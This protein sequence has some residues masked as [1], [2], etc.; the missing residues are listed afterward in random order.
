MSKPL[1]A[2]TDAQEIRERLDVLYAKAR[3]V[4]LYNESC[5]AGTPDVSLLDEK[6]QAKLADYGRSPEIP[7]PILRTLGRTMD[8]HKGQLHAILNRERNLVRTE[9]AT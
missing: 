6:Q 8:V 1:R 4:V 7:L 9:S 2:Y 5:E 3:R